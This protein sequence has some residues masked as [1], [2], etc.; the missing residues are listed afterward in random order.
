MKNPVFKGIGTALITPMTESGAVAYGEAFTYGT[1]MGNVG[2]D[3]NDGD[4][5]NA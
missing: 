4:L 3:T 5:T 2:T 1:E